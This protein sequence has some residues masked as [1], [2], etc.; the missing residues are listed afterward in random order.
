MRRSILALVG[1]LLVATP[2]EAEVRTFE[3][4]YLPSPELATAVCSSAPDPDSCWGELLTTLGTGIVAAAGGL[5]CVGAIFDA[6]PGDEFLICL[7]AAGLGTAA[8]GAFVNW[9]SCVLPPEE[10]QEFLFSPEY[11]LG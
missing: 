5:T 1:M 3:V 4:G 9:A 2:L 6:I 11:D 10:Q 8:L 7:A